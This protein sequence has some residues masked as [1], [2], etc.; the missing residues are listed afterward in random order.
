MRT[1]GKN[2]AYC[3]DL[4]KFVKSGM[5]DAFRSASKPL[6][7]IRERFAGWSLRTTNGGL[8]ALLEFSQHGCSNRVSS[9][10]S[11]FPSRLNLAD[12]RPSGYGRGT[13]KHPF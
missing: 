6:G 4:V 12:P 8:Y 11:S 10:S 3:T 2:F 13:Q 9:V 5:M 7:A 1:G